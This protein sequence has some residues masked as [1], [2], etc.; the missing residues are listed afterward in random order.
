M[1]HQ[2]LGLDC[3]YYTKF[4]LIAKRA[5]ID[6]YVFGEMHYPIHKDPIEAMSAG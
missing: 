3:F 4:C 5:N 6:E 1:P 2:N